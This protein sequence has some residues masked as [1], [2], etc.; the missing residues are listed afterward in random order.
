MSDEIQETVDNVAEQATDVPATIG[1]TVSDRL[2]QVEKGLSELSISVQ[3]KLT[4][5][6][7]RIDTLTTNNQTTENE[8]NNG[9]AETN[10]NPD[11]GNSGSGFDQ[12][13][14]NGNTDQDQTRPTER[15]WYFRKFKF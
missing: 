4:T 8:G 13:G 14:N 5:I 10:A 9:E 3:D 6:L 11:N 2:S 7:D 12:S 1:D 15:H